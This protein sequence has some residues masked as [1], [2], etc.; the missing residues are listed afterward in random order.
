MALLPLKTKHEQIRVQRD[1]LLRMVSD[2]LQRHQN[3]SAFGLPTT[4]SD[5]EIQK[6]AEYA[7]QL[8][9][10]PQQVGFPEV[11]WPRRPS[12]LAKKIIT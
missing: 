7:Q 3:Q 4:Y 5:E 1:A 10:V 11:T 2:I 8:R 6:V 9:D 12:C